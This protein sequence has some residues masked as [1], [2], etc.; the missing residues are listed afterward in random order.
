MY[1]S[2][3]AASIS[4]SFQH[5]RSV[6]FVGIYTVGAG[7]KEGRLSSYSCQHLIDTVVS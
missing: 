6:E 3:K 5:V 4:L 7:V 1:L 2:W